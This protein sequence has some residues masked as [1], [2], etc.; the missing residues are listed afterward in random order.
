MITFAR[1]AGRKA[2]AARVGLG[3]RRFMT[4]MAAPFV[5]GAV[6]A[7][8]ALP[9]L[10][11]G[12][13]DHSPKRV[14]KALL[15]KQ[16]LLPDLPLGSA[17]APVTVIEYASATCPH[18]ADFHRQ[19]WPVLK[20]EYVDTGKVRFIF[21]E[22]P[23]DQV[24]LAAFML[25]RCAAGDDARKFDAITSM[26]MKT[27]GTWVRNPREELMKLMRMAGLNDEQFGACLKNE[28][29]AKNMMNS[30][31]NAS[32][33]LGVHSTPTFFINDLRITGRMPIEEWRKLLDAELA[34]ASKTDR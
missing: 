2:R 28:Q 15:H 12:G 27:Q 22:F 18:C 5:L 3:R 24:A 30:A 31:R 19:E 7:G 29:L 16:P 32:R 17:D 14:N 25:V 21:R 20:K 11:A 13:D 4:M 26:L 1:K 8:A 10:A 33:D 9:A 34:G 6:V 23:L